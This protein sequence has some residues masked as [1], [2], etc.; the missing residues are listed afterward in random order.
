MNQDT[1]RFFDRIRQLIGGG[2]L[3]EAIRL[4]RSLLD[5]SPRLDEALQ[6]SGRLNDLQRQIRIGTVSHENATLTQ[7]QIQMGVLELL[8]E[9]E[10]QQDASPQVRE[11]VEQ[12]VSTVNNQG[13]NIKNQFIGGNFNNPTFN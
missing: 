11:E 10:A 7:N 9:I 2:D 1:P 3:P 8:T 5:N 4:L 6:Q 13:A 12:A